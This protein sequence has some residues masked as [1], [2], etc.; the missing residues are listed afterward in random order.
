MVRAKL[1]VHFNFYP[2]GMEMPGGSW[3]SSKYRYGFNGKEKDPEFGNNYDYGFRIYSS[4]VVR[5]LSV[6]PLTQSYPELTPFQFASNRPI[7][8]IDQDGL[9]FAWVQEWWEVTKSGYNLAVKKVDNV[10]TEAV[11]HVNAIGKGLK[12]VARNVAPIRPADENDPKNAGEAWNNLKNLPNNLSKIPSQLKLVYT[13]G[14]LDEKIETT[15]GLVGTAF[16]LSKGKAQGKPGLTLA[17]FGLNWSWKSSKTFGHLFSRHGQKV[18]MQSL[19]DR[20]KTLSGKEVGQWIDNT[21]TAEYV[22]SIY[23]TL[24]DGENIINIP[25]GLGRVIKADGTVV[26]AAKA[27]IVKNPAGSMNALNTGYPIL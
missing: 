13:K 25:T 18:A 16:A 19:I 7:D 4:K 24:Q 21:K 5:F 9:E 17:S 23:G 26:D 1:L 3:S 6:D 2:F 14:S 8:G 15:V 10:Y 12:S 11:P 20:A 27:I 22:E